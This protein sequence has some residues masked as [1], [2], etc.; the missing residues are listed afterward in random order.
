V[1]KLI[2]GVQRIY[3]L[4]GALELDALGLAVLDITCLEV[5][6]G[7][8]QGHVKLSGAGA[9]DIP[10]LVAEFRLV[11]NP[12]AMNFR[13]GPYDEKTT[14]FV[15]YIKLKLA[16]PSISSVRMLMDWV[17]VVVNRRVLVFCP[18]RCML[19]VD[20]DMVSALPPVG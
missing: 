18:S 10:V 20:M 1:R 7:F 19:M 17:R 16:L 2:D 8:V 12:R 11:D 3:S 14:I 4:P 9:I 15:S 5:G 6:L 13:C